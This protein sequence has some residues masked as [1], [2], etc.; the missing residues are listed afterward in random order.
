MNPFCFLV[1]HI[2]GTAKC[3]NCNREIQLPLKMNLETLRLVCN[4]PQADNVKVTDEVTTK[5]GKPPGCPDKRLA[6]ERR[7]KKWQ[8]GLDKAS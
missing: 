6:W 8:L 3:R 2:E 4:Q 5:F 7:V 1:W